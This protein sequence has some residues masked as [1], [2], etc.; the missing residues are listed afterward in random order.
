MDILYQLPL[1]DEVCSKI[2]L[3]A[4]KTPH[5]DLDAMKAMKMLNI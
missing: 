2:F 3:F 5:T 4:R 1:P